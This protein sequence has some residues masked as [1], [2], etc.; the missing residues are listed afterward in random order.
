[1]NWIVILWYKSYMYNWIHK[2]TG[3]TGDILTLT[4][5]LSLQKPKQQYSIYSF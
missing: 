5:V 3:L 4:T 1:M 2:Q